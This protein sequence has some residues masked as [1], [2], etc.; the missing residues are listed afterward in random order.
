VPDQSTDR[1]I[2]KAVP[3]RRQMVNPLATNFVAP[4][5]LPWISSPEDSLERLSAR[6]QLHANVAQVIGPHGT[7]K[8]T[9][10]E[11]LVPRLGLPVWRLDTQA[12]GDNLSRT[13]ATNANASNLAAGVIWLTLRR[14]SPVMRV[15]QDVLRQTHFRGIL[16]I[17]GAEQ[18]GWWRWQAVRRWA[19]KQGRGLLITAHRDMGL[20]TLYQTRIGDGLADTLLRQAFATAIA[21]TGTVPP[22]PSEIDWPKLLIDHHGNLRECFMDLYDVVEDS[23]RKLK[24][25]GS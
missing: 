23:I 21:E 22:I 15:L 10:L 19:K 12:L 17:D 4:G 9:L 3:A 8:T 5:K 13:S 25:H 1:F 2:A 11:H 18:L 24:E 7:G 16:V 6:L 20:S 14:K